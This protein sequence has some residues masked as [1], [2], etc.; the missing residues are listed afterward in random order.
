VLRIM[1]FL[2]LLCAPVLARDIG[3]FSIAGRASLVSCAEVPKDGGAVLQRGRRG[4]CRRG[5]SPRA[6][7]DPLARSRLAPCARGSGDPERQ[8]ARCAC[9][10]VVRRKGRNQDPLLRPGRRRLILSHRVSP[11]RAEEGSL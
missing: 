9:R 8:S 3:Q 2:V 6:I 10:V 7:L 4:L 5:H 11:I 1:L